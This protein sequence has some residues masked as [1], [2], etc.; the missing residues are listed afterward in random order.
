VVKL[1]GEGRPQVAKGALEILQKA[2]RI[3][4]FELDPAP[5]AAEP[6]AA[7]KP[8]AEPAP[9]AKPAAAAPPA[10]PKPPAAG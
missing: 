3:D 4:R 8:A 2:G 10:A 6:A 9:A 7:P 5:P 1:Q